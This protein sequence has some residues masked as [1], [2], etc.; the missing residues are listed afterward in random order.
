[1]RKLDIKQTK[2][3]SKGKVNAEFFKQLYQLLKICFPSWRSP[4]LID[5]AI[6]TVNLIIRTFLSIHI[7]TL[8][9][10]IVQSAVKID[11][12]MFV[13]RIFEL[14]LISIPASFVNS[15]LEYLNKK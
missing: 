4:V 6:L 11:F 14:G 15:L 3:S 7:S 10:K 5:L 1:L 13:K 12:E 2:S 9:A 8:T